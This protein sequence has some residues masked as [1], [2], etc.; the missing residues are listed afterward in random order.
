MDYTQCDKAENLL[1]APKRGGK[2]IKLFIGIA[3]LPPP[4]TAEVS[5]TASLYAAFYQISAHELILDATGRNR[6]RK[7]FFS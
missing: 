5:A 6:G 2:P 7:F 3:P 4:A 1:K